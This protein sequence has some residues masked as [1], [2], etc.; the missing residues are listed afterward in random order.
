MTYQHVCG[1]CGLAFASLSPNRKWCSRNCRTQA[2][3]CRLAGRPVTPGLKQQQKAMRQRSVLTAPLQQPA[4]GLEMREWNGTAIQRRQ[5]GYVNA[6][7]MCQASGKRW[8]DYV[9]YDRTQE[10]IT[11]LAAHL[12]VNADLRSPLQ[13]SAGNPADLIHTITTGPNDLRGTWIHPRLA[14]DLA[15]WISPAFAVWMDGWFLESLQPRQRTAQL[16][17]GIH[18]VGTSRLDCNRIWAHML[19]KE[20]NAT[21]ELFD[22]ELFGSAA[23][24]PAPVQF[25]IA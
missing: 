7:A 14:V 24:A 1:C 21:L 6:T 18:V 11:A 9:R 3:R 23:A 22:R 5:D 25:H 4:G 15:R 8:H 12:G 13:G 2:Y 16:P 19:R 10:Y 17:Y 20:L